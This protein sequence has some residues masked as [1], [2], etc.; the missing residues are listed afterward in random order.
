MRI[1]VIRKSFRHRVH[2]IVSVF[3]AS[4]LVECDAQSTLYSVQSVHS[5]LQISIGAAV[6]SLTLLLDLNF[7]KD[8]SEKRKP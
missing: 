4:V 1:S 3:Q 7:E 2:A 8:P 5:T 6:D